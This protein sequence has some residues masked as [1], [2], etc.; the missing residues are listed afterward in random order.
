MPRA[1][2]VP[3]RDPWSRTLPLL[4]LGFLCYAVP[5]WVFAALPAAQGEQPVLRIQGSNT[6]GA[7]LAPELVRGLFEAKGLRDIRSEAGAADN[8]QRLL[9]RLEALARDLHVPGAA[10]AVLQHPGFHIG[11]GMAAPPN[12]DIRAR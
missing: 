3:D 1:L 8:E 9:A 4:I 10:A 12:P 5:L 7:K 6:I 11:N 2:S